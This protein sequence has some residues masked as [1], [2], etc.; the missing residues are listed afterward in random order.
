MLLWVIFLSK[1]EF[2]KEQI[3]KTDNIESRREL[4]NQRLKQYIK[5]KSYKFFDGDK[6]L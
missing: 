2:L 3:F 1:I 4:F 5:L 6:S